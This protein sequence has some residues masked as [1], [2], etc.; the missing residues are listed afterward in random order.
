MQFNFEQT[1]ITPLIADIV[2]TFQPALQKN[3]NK[4]IVNCEEELGCIV[5]DPIRLKQIVMNLFSNAIK[6][7]K[8]GSV[9][10]HASR[11]MKE[12]T[13]WV[14]IQVSDTGI[15]IPK[16]TLP[17]LFQPFQQATTQSTIQFS[18]TGL[19]LAISRRMCHEMGGDIKVESQEN[20][21]ATFTIWLPAEQTE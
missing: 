20:Q 13:P 14:T 11:Q 1:K 19:G 7:T 8:N 5:V 18:G 9:T 2:E 15:G 6:F 10:I 17:L 3:N 4:L 12:D 16:K 21:G